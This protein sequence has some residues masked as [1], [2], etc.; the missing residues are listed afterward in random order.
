[1]KVLAILNDTQQTI[2]A[3]V[4]EGK[5]NSEI[6]EKMNYSKRNIK[7]HLERI[8]TYYRIPAKNPQNRRALLI[9]EVTKQ[10]LA[11]YM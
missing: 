3:M 2:L 6:A 8:Y 4:V 9:K 7:Y 1:M 11:K 5:T 10:E